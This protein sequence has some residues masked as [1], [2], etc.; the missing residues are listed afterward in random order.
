MKYMIIKLYDPRCLDDLML[1]LTA[2]EVG[3]AVVLDGRAVGSTLMQ[4]MPIFAGF[5]VDLGE[6]RGAMKVILAVVKDDDH[7]RA[8]RDELKDVGIDLT[9]PAVAKVFLLPIEELA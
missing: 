5:R 7:A 2:H 4:E 9:N 1:A 3:H 8:I 6:P